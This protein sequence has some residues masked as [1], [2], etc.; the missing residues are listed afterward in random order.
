MIG[1]PRHLFRIV[2]EDYINN[3]N[4]RGGA[5]DRGGRWNKPGY[6]IS[7]FGVSASIAMLEMGNCTQ[8]DPAKEVQRFA[9]MNSPQRLL[10]GAWSSNCNGSVNTNIMTDTPTSM[11]QLNR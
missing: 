2:K 5:F 10:L 8:P 7:Y 11:L 3:L 4:G 6:P 1:A 9:C